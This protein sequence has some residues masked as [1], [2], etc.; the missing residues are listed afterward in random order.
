MALPARL[1]PDL[2][3]AKDMRAI[4]AALR[5]AIVTVMEELSGEPSGH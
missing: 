5:D 4:E 2:L 1:A 3:N